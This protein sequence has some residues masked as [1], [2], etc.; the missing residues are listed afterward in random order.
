MMRRTPA[1]GNINLPERQL[2]LRH[3]TTDKGGAKHTAARPMDA[4]AP[5]EKRDARRFGLSI[6]SDKTCQPAPA[7]LGPIGSYEQ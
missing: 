4:T 1:G 2:G 3:C 6:H 5:K 7:D